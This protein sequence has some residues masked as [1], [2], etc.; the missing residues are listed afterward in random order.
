MAQTEVIFSITK[1]NKINKSMTRSLLWSQAV[2]KWIVYFQTI[3]LSYND[4]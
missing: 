3:T 1:K 4:L 2:Q